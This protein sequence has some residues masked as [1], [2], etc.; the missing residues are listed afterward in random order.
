MLSRTYGVSKLHRITR[1]YQLA[2]LSTTVEDT[3]KSAYQQSVNNPQEFWAKQAEDLSWLKKWNNVCAEPN[4]PFP[5]WFEGGK[6]NLCYNCL[7]RHV[8]DG[9]G[10][11]IAAIQE[12]P[13]T[14]T[15]SQY[16]YEVLLD[17]V[18]HLAGYLA[19]DCGIKK[20]DR[21]LIYMPMIVECMIAMLAA[22]RIG[23]LHTV[24]FG[25]F[26]PDQLALRIKNARPRV[27]VTASY[28]VEPKR[29]VAYKAA[30]DEA[31][32]KSTCEDVVE[33]CIFF[34][35]PMLPR[36]GIEDSKFFVDWGQAMSLGRPHDAIPV[37]S[38]HP[39]YL[40]YTS[41]TTGMLQQAP[42]FINYIIWG[43]VCVWR[44]TLSILKR[45]DTSFQNR[46]GRHR[47]PPY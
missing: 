38:T 8:E 30:V 43:R 25:G 36:V 18:T 33:R 10:Q 37:E 31:L 44:G 40:I 15:R 17:Q 46:F 34:H 9:F 24:V 1:Y 2:R 45:N 6:I 27:I 47:T 32:K 16:T 4:S 21:V 41:G 19:R 5:R 29:R 20:G 22:V 14:G 28:G 35:R 39:S 12:S 42:D 13:V 26:S 11:Q 7:D 23:A 3:Y